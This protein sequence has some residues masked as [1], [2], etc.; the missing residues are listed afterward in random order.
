MVPAES[1][2]APANGTRFPSSPVA[3]WRKGH[4]QKT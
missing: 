1:A 4:V 2:G 3:L